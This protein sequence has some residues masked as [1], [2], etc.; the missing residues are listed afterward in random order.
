[1]KV[2]FINSVCGVGS[3]GRICAE[4]ADRYEKE[5][6]TVKIAYGRGKVSMQAERYAVRIGGR[7]NDKIGA[8]HTR[9]T[10]KHGFGNRL[11]TKKFLKWA[12]DYDPDL[13]WL[14]NLHGYYINVEM[15]F[16]W[17]KSRPDMQ[18]KWTLHDCWAFT[19]HCSHFAYVKCDK[20]KTQCENC[21][22]KNEY[23][24]SILLDNS[25]QNYIR[26]KNAFCGVKNLS[27]IC[28]SNWLGNLVKQ[29]FLRE[30]SVEVI[31]NTIDLSVF[32]PTTS[33][34]RL[35]YGLQN[36]KI[37]LGVAF[38][39]GERKGYND[40]FK[41]A[42]LLDNSYQIVLVGVSK[43]QKKA[44]HKNILGIE[45][46]Y[47]KKEMAQIYTAADV[48][49]NLTYEDNYPTVNLEAI[50]CGTPVITYNS[51]GSPE[52]AGDD[53]IVIDAGDIE[54]VATVIKSMI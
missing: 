41:L 52:S 36:K 16:E 32:K 40:F 44:L 23:P 48:F 50:A 6:H 33:D 3:T 20:W 9:L 37:V 7:F 27:L 5:G 8:I 13:I 30:Y 47:D 11:A 53:A 34:F 31:H 45:K 18:V 38:G 51:G 22:Q 29:S 14:H 10:D 28:P 1:M 2:L 39:W 15:L 43:K 46:T 26:K 54:S 24:S 21:V 19:G 25:R 42:D 12:D 49:L 17:I 35:K 4:Q